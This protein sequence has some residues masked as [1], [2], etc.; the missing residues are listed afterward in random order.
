MGPVTALAGVCLQDVEGAH[1]GGKRLLASRLRPVSRKATHPPTYL[2]LHK[3]RK[4]T[5]KDEICVGISGALVRV[6][7]VR[8]TR[9]RRVAAS[10]ARK[11]GNDVGV[12]AVKAAAVGRLLVGR[13][14]RRQRPLAALQRTPLGRS[15]PRWP[16]RRG[17]GSRWCR[18]CGRC[19]GYY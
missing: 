18:Q 7:F 15:G 10:I 3:T 5:R 8:V 13:R 14:R 11:V 19:R 16:G 6:A 2:P 12:K 4:R 1:E 9:L 17:G